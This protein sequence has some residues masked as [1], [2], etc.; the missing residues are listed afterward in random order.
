MVTA[1][2][3]C[4]LAYVAT[5]ITAWIKVGFLTFDIKDAVIAIAGLVLGPIYT[6]II[7]LI[8]ST[9]E[10]I[11]IPETGFWGFLM[12]FL[13]TAAFSFFCALIYKYK[14]DLVGAII[15]LVASIFSMTL[16]MVL[17]N[18]VVTPIYTGMPVETIAP[19]IPTLFL[20]FN[21]TKAVL[22]AA[23]VLMLYKPVSRALKATKMTASV[24]SGKK[25]STK[26]KVL[27]YIV[28][29]SV[30]AI[31]VAASICV[32]IFALPGEFTFFQ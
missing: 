12:N 16:M 17:L 23:L 5:L 21:F 30:G 18:L 26:S 20:P 28:I 25:L 2:L 22:N 13:S 6:I 27:R 1:A 9:I 4:A 24:D 3:F 11:V 19:M 31:L 29:Y 10:I 7:S 14:K 32:L 15:G 8:V